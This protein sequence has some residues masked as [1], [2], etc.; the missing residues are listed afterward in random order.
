M[1]AYEVKHMIC[2]GTIK[3]VYIEPFASPA[4]LKYVAHI[5]AINFV[6]FQAYSYRLYQLKC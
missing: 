6:L 3:G 4:V 5:Q 1:S 2:F